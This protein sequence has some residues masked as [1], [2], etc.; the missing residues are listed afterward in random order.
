MK[1]LKIGLLLENE[2]S[3]SYI[4]ELA[5]W[6]HQQD[7][8]EISNLIINKPLGRPSSIGVGGFTDVRWLYQRISR[9]FFRLIISIEGLFQNF[10]KLHRQNFC[11]AGSESA[12]AGQITIHPVLENGSNTYQF[13][14]LDVR[15]VSALKLDL[16][17]WF[18]SGRIH[19]PILHAARIGVIAFG[20]GYDRLRY[21]D[22]ACFWECYKRKPKTGFS[23]VALSDAS[24]GGD[25]LL[26]GY[27]P[28]KFCFSMNK[29]HVYRK[30]SPHVHN[31]L[32][33]I[34]LTGELPPAERKIHAFSAPARAPELHESLIY[35]SKLLF[36]LTKKVVYRYTRFEKKWGLSF[37]QSN[38]QEL[39]LHLRNDAVAPKGH[40]WADP[41]IHSKDGKTYCFVEDYVY[42]TGLGHIS[43]LD[44]SDES[45][46]HI[47]DCIKE[48]FHL[49]F[50]FLFRYE[51][52]LYMCPEAS[53]SHQIRI[54][55]CTD[56]PLRWELSSIIMDGVSAADSMLFE[57][58]GLWWLL[59]NIDKSGSNDYTSELYLFSA[60]SP[61]TTEWKPH[62]KNPILIDSE[63]G[64]NAGFLKEDGKL[65]RMAQRHG[66]D[67]YGEGL[68]MFEITE[69]TE[70]AYSERIFS[71]M[72]P[73]I[74]KRQIATHHLSTTGAVTVVD[75]LS[76]EFFP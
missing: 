75:H 15:R 38:W 57:H 35:F 63:G 1:T 34:A 36:R 73:S 44:V 58:A 56:F 30:L 18:G 31:F 69:L 40:F 39:N 6:A 59:T 22:H 26:S 51:N 42:K 70:T 72:N 33:R 67:Q 21:G 60:N 55:R 41:F 62:P 28:T 16:L 48:S 71:R 10:S 45:V 61:L 43:V 37:Y 13:S 74:E 12:I 64:R 23:I 19:G 76:R 53:A 11:A 7:G 20:D 50:P 24:V 46:A 3:N 68:L 17:I 14:E 8:L 27:F 32:Q 9:F 52:V 29:A 47:G 5:D 25:V 2:S 65:F 49:S 4:H 54:Y 66:Y